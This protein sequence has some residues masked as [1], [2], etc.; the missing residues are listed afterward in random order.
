MIKLSMKPTGWFH[1]G[2]SAEIAPGGVKPMKY[3]GQDLVA[4]RSEA[5]KLSVLDAHC[6]HLG[7]H[8]GYGSKVRKDCIVCPYHGWEWDGEGDNRLVP[9]Q[10]SP[11]KARMRKWH[12]IERHGIMFLWHDPAGGPP[13]WA[14]PDLFDAFANMPQQEKDYY[15]CY[16]DAVVNKPDERIHVQLMME[17]SADSMHFKYTHGA[18]EFPELLSFGEDDE[19]AFRAMMGFKS[20]K[21]KDVALRVHSARPNVGLVFSMFDGNNMHYRLILAGTPIDDETSYL[22]V[23]YFLPR[24]PQSPDAMPEKVRAFA[25]GTE[26]LFEEDARIWRHQAFIQRPVYARQDIAGYTAFRKWCERFYEAQPGGGPMQVFE[27]SL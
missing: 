24:D 10:E 12:T 13:R 18:P 15:P 25:R 2:W 27:D 21:T 5:G 9:Y 26:E 1:I 7:A 11:T 16:P 4:F 17:N 19:G 20:P 6:R 8:L 23:S 3:F 14:L 22:R